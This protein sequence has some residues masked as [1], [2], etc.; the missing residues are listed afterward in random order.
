[1]TNRRSSQENLVGKLVPSIKNFIG[2]NSVL[3]LFTVTFVMS[4]VFCYN[5]WC[6]MKSGKCSAFLYDIKNRIGQPKKN[7]SVN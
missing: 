1:M 5:N 6:N 4:V 3:F 2:K 7:E